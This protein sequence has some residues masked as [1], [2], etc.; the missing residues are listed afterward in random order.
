MSVG[1]YQVPT[2][3]AV[4]RYGK[5]L[6]RAAFKHKKTAFCQQP[7]PGFS[8]TGSLPNMNSETACMLCKRVGDRASHIG[9]VLAAS[10]P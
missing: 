8:D 9:R 1:S 10:L 3:N 7:I 4:Q 5:R 6:A 2:W